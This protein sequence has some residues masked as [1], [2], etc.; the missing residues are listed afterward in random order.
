MKRCPKCRST[1]LTSTVEARPYVDGGL[2]H[3][4]LANVEVRRCTSCGSEALV[5]PNI[6]GLHRE[7]AK[8]F[9]F[10]R[11]RLIGSELRFLRSYLGLSSSTF[12]EMIGTDDQTLLSWEAS[13]QKTGMTLRMEVVIRALVAARKPVTSYPEHTEMASKAER[14]V[15]VAPPRIRV[16]KRGAFESLSL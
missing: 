8:A 9:T 10:M 14:R 16:Q 12:A 3:V 4:L 5:I 7:I 2:P 15:K 6:A 13:E 1:E 11:A